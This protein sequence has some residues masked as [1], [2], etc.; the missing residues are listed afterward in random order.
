MG[1]VGRR[2]CLWRPPR[3]AKQKNVSPHVTREQTAVLTPA[4]SVPG[5][6]ACVE[7]GWEEEG[8]D[9][10]TRVWTVLNTSFAPHYNELHHKFSHLISRIH[11]CGK[12]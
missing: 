3:S 6:V 9:T 8:Q 12:Y 1:D 10:S 2:H 4:L 11:L 7:G 5:S